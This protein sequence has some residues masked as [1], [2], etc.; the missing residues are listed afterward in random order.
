MARSQKKSSSSKRRSATT[1][2]RSSA[3]RKKE[4]VLNSLYHHDGRRRADYKSLEKRSGN[5]LR[6]LFLFL[7]F[8]AIP[9][10]AAGYYRAYGLPDISIFKA[11]QGSATINIKAPEKASVLMPI[12][13]EV[14][15]A[16]PE[17]QSGSL[18]VFIPDGFQLSTA[19]PQP[20]E[21]SGSRELTWNL[22]A[23]D[24]SGAAPI[25]LVG[26]FSG[27]LDSHKS[28][29]A[30]LTYKPE[31]FESTFQSNSTKTIHINNSP[32][33]LEVTGPPSM[34]AGQQETFV[35]SLT[36]T[37]SEKISNLHIQKPDTHGFEIEQLPSLGDLPSGDSI[38]VE[39]KGSFS[40]GKKGDTELRWFITS[41]PTAENAVAS[42]SQQVN[43]STDPLLLELSLSNQ[44]QHLAS[45]DNLRGE[46][47][48]H[49]K[50]DVAMEDVQ[51]ILLVDAPAL[52]KK[53]MLNWDLLETTGS[54]EVIGTQLSDQMRRGTI[55]W[56]SQSLPTLGLIDPQSQGVIS[57][58]L[59]LLTSEQ[60]DLTSIG[61]SSFRI[62]AQLLSGDTVIEAQPILLPLVS[63]ASLQA[64]AIKAGE[65]IVVQWT[66]NHHVH[67]INNIKVSTK[68]FNGI[69]WADQ[70]DTSEGS[71]LYN[72]N[73]REVVWTVAKHA[74][75]EG[76][77]TATFALRLEGD[78]PT[79]TAI[80]DENILSFNDAI[81]SKT[82]TRKVPPTQKP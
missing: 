52:K 54:P 71:V 45:G 27:P 9:I 76:P 41:S 78:D 11:R 59:P 35:L 80:T 30:I 48:Y 13:I 58:A 39:I 77:M 32:L 22:S 43:V 50:N 72:E 29:R 51:I 28:F 34:T 23:E 75:T 19:L 79:Q 26:M 20:A 44:P 6:T 40:S 60:L 21:L 73:S 10:G 63:D 68:L 18:T 37:G 14:A 38:E 65:L 5:G 61:A 7:L 47:R 62:S 46:L 49:N 33:T 69:S 81:A 2:R 4:K 24:F 55:T 67:Q 3:K 53:S 36:N 56:D 66:L 12:S 70:T 16:A 17:A 15:V 74:P 82:I 1:P 8:I 42:F 25:S 64:G 57:F 31:N